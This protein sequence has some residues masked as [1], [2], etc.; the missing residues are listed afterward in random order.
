MPFEAIT[1]IFYTTDIIYMVAVLSPEMG[2]T[3]TLP[4]YVR[5]CACVCVCLCLFLCLPCM[6][7]IHSLNY[8]PVLPTMHPTYLSHIH[9]SIFLS[10]STELNL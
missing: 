2:F 1:F 5:V 10:N 4:V 6:Q 9:P 7:S 3:L 8:L